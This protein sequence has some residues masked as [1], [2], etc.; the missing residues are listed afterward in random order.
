MATIREGWL[1]IDDP[2]TAHSYLQK[3]KGSVPWY[4]G[5]RIS[6]EGSN[7]YITF[8]E[9]YQHII[10]NPRLASLVVLDEIQRMEKE[11]IICSRFAAFGTWWRRLP[12]KISMYFRNFFCW[13]VQDS[14]Q[15]REGAYDLFASIKVRDTDGKMLKSYFLGSFEKFIQNPMARKKII[16]LFPENDPY[17]LRQIEGELDLHEEKELAALGHTFDEVAREH[18]SKGNMTILYKVATIYRETIQYYLK[19]PN[20]TPE[21]RKYLTQTETREAE[22]KILGRKMMEYYKEASRLGHREASWDHATFIAPLIEGGYKEEYA[23]YS[24]RA[25]QQ[26]HI[27]ALKHFANSERVKEITDLS[28]EIQGFF[29]EA[30]IKN[31]WQSWPNKE[32]AVKLL[33]KAVDEKWS[34]AKEALSKLEALPPEATKLVINRELGLIFKKRYLDNPNNVE[35]K[36]RAIRY[37]ELEKLAKRLDTQQLAEIEIHF[38]E[39]AS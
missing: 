6:I 19:P 3:L 18:S 28:P 32:L 7:D 20:N 10:K 27:D 36:K 35:D 9:V 17:I 38:K 23:Y 29:V 33:L 25:L 8:K 31:E 37:F 11:A 34:V 14:Q 21:R 39:L 15:A 13:D 24:K 5:R 2:F 16:Q 26:G 1:R 30:L 22:L 4:G 12:D